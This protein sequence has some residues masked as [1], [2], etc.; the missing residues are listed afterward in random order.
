MFGFLYKAL[1]AAA[2]AAFV[3]LYQ[4]N[5]NAVCKSKRRLDGRTALVT[6]GTDGIGLQ[7]AVDFAS[8][9]A[10]VLVC[11]P[12]RKEGADAL[13]VI[14]KESGN[15][16]VEFKHLN[17]ASLESVRLFASDVTKS[18]SRLDILVNNAGIVT[19]G[20]SRTKD[21]LN[22]LMQ[23]NYFGHYLLTIL[24]LPL[25]IKTGRVSEPSRIVNTGSMLH[26]VG[27]ID[28]RNLNGPTA[29]WRLSQ[30]YGSSKLALITFTFELAR[31]LK[32][33]DVVVN[34]V[35]PGVVGTNLLYGIGL[36]FGAIMKVC[37]GIMYKTP[38]EG[39][40]TAIYAA[41]DDDAGKVSG[42]YFSNC[43][44]TA[45]NQRAYDGKTGIALWEESARLVNLSEEELKQCLKGVQV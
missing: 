28:V 35:D 13:K 20:S 19:K 25:L 4:K 42:G 17:L 31:R 29:F 8:R 18:E 44:I 45:A 10:R 9:G 24:L 15:K 39:A 30:I 34:A 12:F 22:F 33:S 32:G 1:A 37:I 38:W 11:S 14:I 16:N 21:G 5:R 26:H 27:Y 23:V 7:I 40:Q 43:G 41:V 6:G 36:V 3:G 2:L